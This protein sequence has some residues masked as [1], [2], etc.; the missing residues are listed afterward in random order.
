MYMATE[1]WC[2]LSVRQIKTDN[3]ILWSVQTRQFRVI[4][5]LSLSSST[6]AQLKVLKRK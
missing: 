3:T 4:V 2:V 5:L 6:V 1:E